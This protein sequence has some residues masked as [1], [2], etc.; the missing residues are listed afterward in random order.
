MVVGNYAVCWW[1]VVGYD[2]VSLSEWFPTSGVNGMSSSPCSSG[3][4][5]KVGTLDALDLTS[6]DT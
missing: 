2:A 3:P 6:Q 4:A 5:R 1:M